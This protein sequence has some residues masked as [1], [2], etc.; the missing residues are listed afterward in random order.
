MNQLFFERES[1]SIGQG[2]FARAFA[3][4]ALHS[5][6]LWPHVRFDGGDSSRVG[7]EDE[8]PAG[9]DGVW[10][11]QAGVNSLAVDKF[12]HKLY[13]KWFC[14]IGGVLMIIGCLLAEQIQRLKCGIWTRSRPRGTYRR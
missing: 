9:K 11:C 6:R 5:L 13:V 12:E 14:I 4:Q 2:T 10:A 1:A 7:D 3:S 8:R